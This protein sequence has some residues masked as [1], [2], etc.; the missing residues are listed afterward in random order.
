MLVAPFYLVFMLLSFLNQLVRRAACSCGV[1]KPLTDEERTLR[2]TTIG[3]KLNAHLAGWQ[4]TR[5]LF[6]CQI[7]CLCLWS[8]RYFTILVNILFNWLIVELGK[9]PWPITSLLFILIGLV[10]FLLPVVP[11]PVVY[12]T[13]GVLVVPT[14]EYQLGG[15]PVEPACPPLPG[16]GA[17]ATEALA[18]ALLGGANATNLPTPFC[19]EATRDCPYGPRSEIPFWIGAAW[20]NVISYSLKLVAHILQQKLIGETLGSRVGIRAMVSPNSRLMKAIRILLSQPGI[21]MAKVSIMCGGPDWPTSV[22]CGFLKLRL[23]NLLLGLTPMFLMTVPTTLTG[24]FLN[25]PLPAYKSIANFLFL[26]VLFVQLIFGVGMMHYGRRL[27]HPPTHP[28]PPRV[29][30]APT[31]LPTHPPTRFARSARSGQPPID[32]P[33]SLSLVCEQSTACSRGSQRTLPPSPTTSRSRRS[34]RTRRR[35]TSSRRSSPAF[36]TFRLR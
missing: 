7:L 17:N 5:A 25:P 2:F 35:A 31:H 21:S 4:W 6:W 15:R 26:I 11:G 22:I 12:L 9:F 34:R 36:R 19:D 32:P 16:M 23:C 10:M 33:P 13:C 14:M 24:A 20:A 28:P 1:C 29:L 8:Y 18:L 27:P 30:L 3:T